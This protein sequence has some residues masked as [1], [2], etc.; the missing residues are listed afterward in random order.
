MAL[1]ARAHHGAET[2]A[3]TMKTTTNSSPEVSP[4]IEAEDT[5]SPALDA[6]IGLGANL[7]DRVRTLSGAVHALGDHGALEA[8]SSL[9]ATEPVGPPQPGFLNAA[10]RIRFA[11]TPASLLALLLDVERRFGRERRE[12][13][14]PRVLDLDLLW[15]EGV[16]VQEEELSVPHPRLL[17]RRFA[18]EPLLEVAPDARDPRTGV[19]LAEHLER[20]APGGV[21]RVKGP[22]WAGSRSGKAAAPGGK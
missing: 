10:A 12:R 8:V 21:A 6:V 22:E 13:W 19:L 20:L 14:G 9:Y 5:P 2:T 7:G 4:S 1:P 3:T 16:A 17:S 15:I 11:G 18:L